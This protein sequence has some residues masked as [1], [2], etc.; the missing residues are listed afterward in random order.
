[1]RKKKRKKNLWRII[2]ILFFGI[3]IFA[4]TSIISSRNRL[5]DINIKD[6]EYVEIIANKNDVMQTIKNSREIKDIIGILNR[7]RGKISN[8]DSSADVINYINV[9]LNS[10]KKIEF[11][12]SG[13][14]L[15]VDNKWYVLNRRNSDL[16][17]KIIKKYELNK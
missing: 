16:L 9:Y 10:G 12:K 2:L 14:I 11:V 5:V 6:V 13:Q 8:R 17:E 4:G 7:L 1:M 3:L 15:R